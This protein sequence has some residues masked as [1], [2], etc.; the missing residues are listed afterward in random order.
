M[1]DIINSDPIPTDQETFYHV[2]HFASQ[3]FQPK[4]C[5]QGVKL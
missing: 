4:S 5:H 1:N 2:S 3:E